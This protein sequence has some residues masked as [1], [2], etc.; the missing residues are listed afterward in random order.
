MDAFVPALLLH[1]PP[2][3][4]SLSN[5]VEPT[6]TEA[7]VFRIAVIGFTVTVMPLAQP[8]PVTV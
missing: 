8:E 4:V 3:V 7:G 1:A 5:N 6:H 2:D